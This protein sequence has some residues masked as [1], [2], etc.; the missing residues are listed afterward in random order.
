MF[1]TIGSIFI[2]VLLDLLGGETL[3]FV[4][5]EVVAAFLPR[6][7]VTVLHG[8]VPDPETDQKRKCLKKK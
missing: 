2:R 5:L 8:V 1:F 6:F 4:H 7:H 3:V